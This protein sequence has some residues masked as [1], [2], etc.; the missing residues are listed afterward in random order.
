MQVGT[1]VKML[2]SEFKD[3]ERGRELRNIRNIA[4]EAGKDNTGFSPLSHRQ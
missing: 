1:D 4:L 2:L 3:G